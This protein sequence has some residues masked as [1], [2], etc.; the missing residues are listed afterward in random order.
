MQRIQ[1]VSLASVNA[2]I[3]TRRAQPPH[4]AK[5]PASSVG[6][7]DH[8]S[9]ETRALAASQIRDGDMRA[10]QVLAEKTKVGDAPVNLGDYFMGVLGQFRDESEVLNPMNAGIYGD[11]SAGSA[12]TDTGVIMQE[13]ASSTTRPQSVEWP[14]PLLHSA[15]SDTR[16]YI[17]T[18]TM[19]GAYAGFANGELATQF[20]DV[21]GLTVPD[22]VVKITLGSFNFPHI[23]SAT[24]TIFDAFYFRSVFV[25]FRFIP[26]AQQVQTAQPNELFTFECFVD[27]IDSSAVMLRPLEPTFC[28]SQPIT[29]SGNL[30][31]RFQTR[32]PSGRGFVACPIPPTRVRVARTTAAPG[33]P[34]TFTITDSTAIDDLAPVG[35]TYVVPV[36]FADYPT[37]TIVAS[38]ALRTLLF[39]ET[40][41]ATSNFTIGKTF[42]IPLDSSAYPVPPG[43]DREEY[44]LIIPKNSIAFSVRFSCLQS[45]KTNELLPL[46]T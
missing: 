37:S 8:A 16:I 3:Y 6:R 18:L 4:A 43:P 20:A 2:P 13:L 23:H 12:S 39:A 38:A 40:G 25:S 26:T 29:P 45:N 11:V 9:R 30:A 42:T 14:I 44:Y 17:D 41:F 32:A 21:R 34:T 31:V 5:T 36:I 35:S 24:T 7:A 22:R 10:A 27:D 28:L 15:I 33:G 46:H 19:S 1:P